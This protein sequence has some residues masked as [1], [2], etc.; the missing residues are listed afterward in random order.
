METGTAPGSLKGKAVESDHEPLAPAPAARLPRKWLAL[1]TLLLATNIGTAVAAVYYAVRASAPPSALSQA[2][3]SVQHS[4]PSFPEP[5]RVL[6]PNLTTARMQRLHLDYGGSHPFVIASGVSVIHDADMVP[7]HEVHTEVVNGSTFGEYTLRSGRVGPQTLQVRFVDLSSGAEAILV[8]M[9]LSV[10]TDGPTL[11]P[12][13]YYFSHRA[14]PEEAPV[15]TFVSTVAGGVAFQNDVGADQ[16]T[17]TMGPA[18]LAY[19]EAWLAGHP[20]AAAAAEAYVRD[21]EAASRR[22]LTGFDSYAAGKVGGMLGSKVGGS[23]WGGNMGSAVGRVAEATMAGDETV[24]G[25][26]H[27]LGMGLAGAAAT[28]LTG[29]S[30]AGNAVWAA[31]AVAHGKHVGDA[32]GSV[33]GGREGATYGATVGSDVGRA[34]GAALGTAV[35]GPVGGVVGEEV[36]SWGGGLAGGYLGYKVG[37]AIGGDVGTDVD[38]GIHDV[39]HAF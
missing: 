19:A 23:N 22:R 34:A 26:A 18:L 38:H 7:T 15:S 16:W 2:V 6:A 35:G 4:D 3:F 27:S 12:N 17:A 20:A 37:R 21:E 10:K 1:G 33:A 32:V 8:P 36:G 24:G 11:V 29:T 13:L 30:W 25:A 31:S 5:E 14:R 28:K 39:E 9:S